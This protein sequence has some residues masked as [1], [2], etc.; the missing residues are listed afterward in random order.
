MAYVAKKRKNIYYRKSDGTYYYD[1]TIKGNR[2]Y[3]FG[4]KTAKEAE[5]ALIIDLQLYNNKIKNITFDVLVNYYEKHLYE[6]LKQST[7]YDKL[8]YVKKYI[9]P[10]FEKYFLKQIKIAD[11]EL[12][13]KQLIKNT[14]Q[15]T[16]KHVNRI[17]LVCKDLF[18]FLHRRFYIDTGYSALESV[19]D[20]DF[21]KKDEIWTLK[22]FNQFITVID[23]YRYLVLFHFM[24][25]YGVRLGE[26]VGLKFKNVNFST[27]EI[28]INSQVVNDRKTH[29]TIDTT[30][31][32]KSSLRKFY[33]DDFTMNLI[34][35]LYSKKQV[36]VFGI[37][38]A[39]LSRTTIRRHFNHYITL[40]GVKKIRIHALRKSCS[41]RLY[42]TLGDIKTVGML[43]GHSK[44]SMTMYYIQAQE[45][46]QL[47]M[48]QKMEN[49]IKKD[50]KIYINLHLKK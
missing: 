19:K 41:T 26:A 6:K 21:L 45:E 11:L 39:P 49:M 38:T 36:Y 47:K 13:K 15:Y 32:T 23:D 50:N 16:R 25:Y 8:Q 5:E 10:F 20:T 14:K 42:N 2:F 40:S 29:K 28:I 9:T 37:K 17:I 31:K 3:A 43:L 35:K 33:V 12:W 7:A 27:K 30:L 48:I 22:E 24:F 4:F 1:K 34:Q 18:A 44:E 46:K